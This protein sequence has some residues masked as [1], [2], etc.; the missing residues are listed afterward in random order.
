[1]LTTFSYYDWLAREQRRRRHEVIRRARGW[2]VG[3]NG[4][5]LLIAT[6]FLTI[7]STPWW[8]RG[9]WLTAWILLAF[10]VW[11]VSSN[12]GALKD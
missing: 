2:K 6:S 1:M 8:P 9:I 7:E 12:R 5:L 3:M 4:G 11:R 10:G